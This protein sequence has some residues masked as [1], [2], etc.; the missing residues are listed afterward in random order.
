MDALVER[1]QHQGGSPFLSN[2]LLM[3]T[4][5][6]GEDKDNPQAALDDLQNLLVI[7]RAEG[8]LAELGQHYAF[9]AW[10]RFNRRRRFG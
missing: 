8:N 1:L 2:A 7:D 4:S 3:R 6:R 10:T 9:R 5:L